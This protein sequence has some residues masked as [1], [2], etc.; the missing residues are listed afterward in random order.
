MREGSYVY[1][2]GSYIAEVTFAA[3]ASPGTLAPRSFP[4]P[5]QWQLSNRIDSRDLLMVLPFFELFRPLTTDD[6][7][8]WRGDYF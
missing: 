1:A 5:P 3:P 2:G 4:V 7:F 6:V 8:Y